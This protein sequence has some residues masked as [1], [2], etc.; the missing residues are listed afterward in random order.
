[1][2]QV[3]D[4][5]PAIAI[6]VITR[7]QINRNVRIGAFTLK[8]SFERLSVHFDPFHLA[9]LGRLGRALRKKRIGCAH[10]QTASERHTA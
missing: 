9:G 3:D 1:V 6:R 7:G 8:V 5:I 4:R 10:D 2:E